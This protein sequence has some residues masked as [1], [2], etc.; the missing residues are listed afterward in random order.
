[1]VVVAVVD[2]RQA[3]VVPDDAEGRFNITRLEFSIIS[4]LGEVVDMLINDELDKR[5][6]SNLN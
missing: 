3:V 5:K 2:E 6:Y 4:A 1:M